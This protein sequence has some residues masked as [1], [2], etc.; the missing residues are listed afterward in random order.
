MSNIIAWIILVLALLIFSLGGYRIKE[1]RE[2]IHDLEDRVLRLEQEW[3][4][5]SR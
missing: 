2:D 5:V 4:R 1:F 3:S